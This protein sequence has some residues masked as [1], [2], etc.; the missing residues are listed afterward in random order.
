MARVL[1]IDERDGLGDLLVSYLSDTHSVN[2][3]MRAPQSEDGFGGH[4]SG[5][6]SGLIKEQGIDTVV[7]SPPLRAGEIDLE[8]AESV[9]RQCAGAGIEK[10]VLLSSAMVYGASPH[11]QG[12]LAETQPILS[13]GNRFAR[14]W[15]KLEALAISFFGETSKISAELTI[16]RPAAVLVPGSSE[17]FSRL[18]QARMAITLPGHDPTMQLLS[19]GDLA[20]AVRCVL[21]SSKAGV[22][23]VAPRR[24]ITLR[25]ALRQAGVKRVPFSRVAQRAIRRTLQATGLVRAIDQLEY[26]RYSWTISGKKISRELLFKPQHSS[27]EALAEFRRDAGGEIQPSL[28][29][30]ALQHDFDDFGMDK[31]YIASFGRTL[32][33]FLHDFYWRV[34]VKGLDLVPRQGRAVLVGIHRGFMPWDGVMALHVLVQKLDRY[35]RFLIH[36][37]LIKFP[38]LFNYMTK[39][40]G[41]VACQENGAYV[42]ERDGM[43]GVFPEG[44]RGAFVRYRDAYKLGKFGRDE[45]VKMALRHRAPIVPFVTVG[46]AEIFP[47]IGKINW[48]WW[49]RNTEWPTFPI[50]PTF[51]FLPPIPL[52]AKWHTQF[53]PAIHIEERYPPEAAGDPATVRAISLEVRNSMEEAVAEMLHRRKSIFYGSIFQDQPIYETAASERLSYESKVVYK[54]RV[55]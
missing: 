21:E 18:F 44:I 25:A 41:I 4:L 40:G 22:Y 9:C 47:I 50:T 28:N 13:G 27:A 31:N 12:L 11:N 49:K 1:V 52:P 46:S 10:F 15:Y 51:P 5:G 14:A 43:L 53:L 48:A 33:K 8:D 36:P 39:L 30:Q 19:P 23:N 35:P 54:E 3:C 55:S 29:Q 7:Y 34:E 2:A 32:F 37:G 38:F 24:T 20:A 42:L 26:I 17:Y 45:Y 16:L 6:Y